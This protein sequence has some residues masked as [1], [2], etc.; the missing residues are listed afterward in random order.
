M[1]R[2]DRLV[3]ED[4]LSG[5]AVEDASEEEDPSTLYLQT[6]TNGVGGIILRDWFWPGPAS[7]QSNPAVMDWHLNWKLENR[8]DGGEPQGWVATR[9]WFSG[10]YGNTLTWLG[11]D[12]L[13]NREFVLRT[14]FDDA[15]NDEPDPHESRRSV[16]LT[17]MDSLASGPLA[18]VPLNASI[19]LAL[20][21]EPAIGYTL[22]ISWERGC[23]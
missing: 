9:G 11:A 5:R 6:D 20:A 1:L 21:I 3:V 7:M 17:V 15:L 22:I 14:W 8:W 23:E 12:A 13:T 10:A 4:A 19:S 16:N 2:W 18:F